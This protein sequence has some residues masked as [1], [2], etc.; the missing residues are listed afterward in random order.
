MASLLFKNNA[1]TTLSGTI[2]NTQTSITVASSSGFPAPTAG[3]YFYATMYELSGTTEINI[4]IVKVTAV[5]GTT[6]T[7]VRGQDSTTG[8][9]RSTTT[10]I[11][12]RYT[13]AAAALML[14]KDNNLSDLASAGTARTNLGLGTMATQN[15]SSV[16][17][18]GGTISGV[19]IET[20]D[21]ST[22][23]DDNADPTKKAQFEVSGIATAT[24]RTFSFPNASGT[25]ALTSDLSAGYQPLDSDLTAFAALS[26]NGIVAR[27][28]TG[29]VAVRSLAAPT[30]GFTITNSDGV[31][32]NPTFVLANDLGAVE[33]L[34]TTG[35][36]RRT[37]ADT[38][39]ASALV[40]G[41]L[42]SALTGKTYNG[43]SLTAN[44]TG[45]TVAGGSTTSKAVQFNNNLTIAG[46]DGTTI[47]LP[48][49]SGTVALTDQT[50]FIGTTSVAI[51]RASASLTLSGVNISGSAGTATSATSATT[52][53]NL[54]GG[55]GTTL[56][57]SIPYQ[58]GTDT[59]T[60]LAPNTTAT[61]RFLSQTGTGT[62]GAAPAWATLTATDVGL[63]SV[64][65]TALSTWAG[66]ANIT[67]L[68]TVA[69]GTWNATT[70]GITK[71]GT[72]QTTAAA[73]FNALSPVTTLGDL[74]YGSAANTNSRL[75]GNT[76]T[77]RKFL[78]Q[79]GDGVNS[80]APAWDTLTDADLPATLTGKTYNG[81]T[82][83]ALSVGWSG[84]G[85]A[86]SKTLTVSNTLTLAGT[87]SSTLNI[88]AG[89]TLGSAAFTAST[90]YAP[91]AGSSSITTVGT[92][93]SGTWTGSTIGLSSG[94]TGATSAVSARTAL[95][96]VI[97]TDIPSVTGSGASGSWGISVTGSA[98]SVAW[99]S[100]TGRP[101]AVSSFTNDSGYITSSSLSP[102][103]P[104]AGGT[105]TGTLAFANATSPNT[106]T[107]QFGDGSGWKFR[108]MTNISG[109]P[110]ERFSFSDAGAFNSLGAI[111][112]NG[113]QVLHASNYTSYA[114][115]LTGSGASG[116]WGINITGSA[117]SASTATSATS[118]TTAT[119]ATTANAL[120]TS[121]NYQVSSLGVGTAAN[122]TVGDIIASRAGGTT[123]IIYFGTS[124][125]RYLYFDG[126]SYNMPGAALSVNSKTVAYVDG[127]NS[128]GT[129]GINVTG[130]AG[131]V[132]WTSV[133]GRPTAVSSF[134]N[135]SGYIT[136]SSLSPYA[137]LASPTFT[138]NVWLGSALGT[139]SVG[140]VGVPAG[141]VY[142]SAGSTVTLAN[143]LRYNGAWATI[144][145]G[146]SGFYL[147]NGNAHYWYSAASVT[148]GSAP[149]LTSIM[150]LD[151]SGNLIAAANVSAYSDRRL[152]SDLQRIENALDKVQKLTGYTYTR[153]DLGARQTG[154]IAQ[155]VQ[156]VLP[157]AVSEDADGK[158]ALAYGNVMGL[159]VEAIKELRAEI[160]W[161]KTVI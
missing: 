87:D 64:E 66:S 136:S 110:T 125:T 148:A 62:N 6:W 21:S 157:E 55:N 102:Y 138:G 11:E 45:F 86:T 39:A 50:M 37:A 25:F 113:N 40:D 88:G 160:E 71:G 133:T 75:A 30:A 14:Q 128:S 27:T 29:T 139:T 35:F 121:N 129:W 82:L 81:V 93:T 20:L 108:F 59:T 147:I 130:S 58:S 97:G 127:T 94:G 4:E 131:S 24:T 154:L 141:G 23:I 137:P 124:G 83:T 70:I 115:S 18:T 17:I 7:I 144:A 78:R 54:S 56:L 60:Q 33:G 2:T 44:V 68:G 101:T 36:V 120:N 119:T 72:G 79:T 51:N 47:T 63:G 76:T 8:L 116:T 16:A 146:T 156:A 105:I 126:T 158:L 114:P 153:T 155:D 117:G 135:D 112:Q 91:A 100:V 145:T 143:N 41:D 161:I 52:S 140:H 53:T 32:G 61:K 9:T 90:A 69:T 12:L 34:A 1:S 22:T 3:D 111:T 96:L 123:G 5:S 103:L 10:Y 109:T 104:L 92:I 122:G 28:G 149:T 98:G 152:K 31:S 89:G 65:N 26:A 46:T 118:A 49:T 42:P 106:N 77:T 134:T 95:G 57:G 150:S 85:G 151:G 48:A 142:S 15:A 13:S 38:W 99:T 132:A 67:T 19:T 159:V 80:A 84:A 73:A 74:I 43:L 107:I